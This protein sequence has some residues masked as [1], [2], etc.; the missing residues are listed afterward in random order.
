MTDE[1][2]NV[3]LLAALCS[4]AIYSI[5]LG[6]N[7]KTEAF[8]TTKPNKCPSLQKAECQTHDTNSK[9]HKD[10]TGKNK[11]YMDMRKG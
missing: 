10:Y 2:G 5:G 8:D 9:Y 4:S 7:K 3:T 6:D 1:D 11:D